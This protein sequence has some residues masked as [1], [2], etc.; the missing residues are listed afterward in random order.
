MLTYRRSG[1]RLPHLSRAYENLMILGSE[2]LVGI[3][4]G[5]RYLRRRS[6]VGLRGV[7]SAARSWSVMFSSTAFINR[8]MR[9]ACGLVRGP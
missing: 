7:M 2:G 6:V 1:P 4:L 5:E 9:V 3:P 8:V